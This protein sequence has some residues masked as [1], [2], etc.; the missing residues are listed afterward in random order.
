MDNDGDVLTTPSYT[1]GSIEHQD[2]SD[3]IHKEID[4]I[5]DALDDSLKNSSS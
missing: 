3:E 5:R 2:L 1:I 4:E